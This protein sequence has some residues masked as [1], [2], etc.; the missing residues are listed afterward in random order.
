[1]KTEQIEVAPGVKLAADRWVPSPPASPAAT[2]DGPA[3]TCLLVHGLAS[4]ARM[5]DGVAAALT[6]MG[7][8]VV[9]VDLR[10]HGRSSKPDT[11]YDVPTVAN[12]LATLI[13]RMGLDR[14]IAAGQSWGGNVVLELAARHPAAVR[15]IALVDGGWIELSE[16]FP[17][18]ADCLVAL[19]PPRLAG[20][21]L[22][23]V[24]GYVRSAHADWPESGIRGTLGNFE[25]RPD[26]TIAPWLTYDRH[27]IVLRGLWEHHP[28]TLY[29]GLQVPALLIPAEVGASDWSDRKR[30]AVEQAQAAIPRATTH[31]MTGDHD[32]HA[33][34]PDE[35]AQVL[36]ELAVED[37][38]P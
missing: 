17:R 36:H 11:G 25:V 30:H 38:A 29:A 13:A 22:R 32:L 3:A 37:R 23:E 19:A 5:W 27:L 26:G 20:R 28:A 31:W 6:A 9:T 24:E 18:L 1:M 21:P 35:V 16:G 8:P 15:A 2:A 7:H 34:H 14:P 4:N 33:Q 12:D 10:G